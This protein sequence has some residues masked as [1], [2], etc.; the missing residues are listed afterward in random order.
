MNKKRKT[1]LKRNVGSMHIS[2][3]LK[4]FFE[5]RFGLGIERRVKCQVKQ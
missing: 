2:K 4:N 3:A 5:E 1:I